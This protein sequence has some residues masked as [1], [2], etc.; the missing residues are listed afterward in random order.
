MS[1]PTSW[2]L[3]LL[4]Q[5]SLI[6]QLLPWRYNLASVS[7]C[8]PPC[9][10]PLLYLIPPSPVVSASVSQCVVEFASAAQA[11]RCVRAFRLGSLP[12]LAA[13]VRAGSVPKLMP[14]ARRGP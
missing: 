14:A 10:P 8:K 1:L 4:W 11:E 7:H 2:P 9:R 5:Y 3:L 13:T 6:S 12:T